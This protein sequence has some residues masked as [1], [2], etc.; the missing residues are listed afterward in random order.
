MRPASVPDWRWLFAAAWLALAGCGSTPA[1]QP[2]ADRFGLSLEFSAHDETGSERLYRVAKDGTI[3]F[4]GG[5]KARVGSTTWTGQMTEQEQR[6]LLDVIREQEWFTREIESTGQPDDR[7]YR[8]TVNAA[9]GHE[10][11]KVVGCNPRVESV[12]AVLE[13]ICRRRLDEDLKRLPEPSIRERPT[14][15]PGQSLFQY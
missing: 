12:E 3:S 14:T 5:F 9:E 6:E 15:Q 4:G 8:V 1:T 10:R 13:Q 7:V 2:M 11:F